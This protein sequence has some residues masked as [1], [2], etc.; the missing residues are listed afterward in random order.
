MAMVYGLNTVEPNTP[1]Q[2]LD[3]IN[4][5]YNLI[6]DKYDIGDAELNTFNLTEL[7]SINK[8]KATD[9]Q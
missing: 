4:K 9:C 5:A 6:L 1:Q 8:M 3:I 7:I 2:Q